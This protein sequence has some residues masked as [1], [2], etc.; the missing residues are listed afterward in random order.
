MYTYEYTVRYRI[1]NS[2]FTT[3]SGEITSDC[4]L[5]NANRIFDILRTEVH[6]AVNVDSF[7]ITS[8]KLKE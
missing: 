6:K 1:P 3:Y 7:S 8:F 5:N 2:V 4:L